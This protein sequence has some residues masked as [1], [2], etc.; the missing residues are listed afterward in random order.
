[1]P[2]TLSVVIISNNQ[3]DLLESALLSARWAN[4][5]IVLDIGSTDSSLAVARHAQCKATV[6][7][8]LGKNSLLQLEDI[9]QAAKSDWI[10]WLKTEEIISDALRHE[11]QSVLERD[12]GM[13]S[14]FIQRQYSYMDTLLKEPKADLELRLVRKNAWKN[15]WQIIPGK[16][17]QFHLIEKEKGKALNTGLQVKAFSNLSCFL[18]S[19]NEQ[20]SLAAYRTLEQN[21]KKAALGDLGSMIIGAFWT[22]LKGIIF[23]PKEIKSGTGYH[24][25]IQ[26]L[27]ILNPI[28]RLAK[29]RQI[30]GNT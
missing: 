15:A 19:L 24:L 16:E 30:L 26:L 23:P 13:A 4:E 1:M 20:S 25:V 14:F 17:P 2:A 29:I 21:G 22:I 3:A 5:R 9:C 11:I 7:R 27:L 18:N 8:Q 6:Y 28:V 10:L 12:E